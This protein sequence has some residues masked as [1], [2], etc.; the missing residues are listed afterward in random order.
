MAPGLPAKLREA[1]A[2]FLEQGERT[3]SDH[4]QDLVR[5]KRRLLDQAGE[6]NGGDQFTSGRA[7]SVLGEPNAW[8]LASQAPLAVGS[9]DPRKIID[10]EASGFQ[11]TPEDEADT[12]P[13]ARIAAQAA[14]D[15][16]QR[17]R[18]AMIDAEDGRAST[19]A[20]LA[21]EAE[22]AWAWA[23]T[24]KCQVAL[25]TRSRRPNET[26]RAT[27]RTPWPKRGRRR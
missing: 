20:A 10:D 4:V 7:R 1:R 11:W 15:K 17:A 19:P 8:W 13:Q 14:L 16:A 24:M 5:H 23:T 12:L 21:E 6:E 2:T 9:R 18:Q 26:P 25:L 27:T 22:A 3:L